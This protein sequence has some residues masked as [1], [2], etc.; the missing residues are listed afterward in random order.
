VPPHNPLPLLVN[1]NLILALMLPDPPSSCPLLLLQTES[2]PPPIYF[3]SPLLPL[4]STLCV[5]LIAILSSTLVCLQGVVGLGGDLE[6]IRTNSSLGGQATIE[7]HALRFRSNMM[8][9]V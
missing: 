4:L 3:L 8:M 9:M 5:H 1:F 6:G 2:L 7:F